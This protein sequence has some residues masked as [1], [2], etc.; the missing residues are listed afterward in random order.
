MGV[1]SGFVTAGFVSTG[2][3]FTS[4][5]VVEKLLNPAALLVAL[6]SIEVLAA[7]GLF[8]ATAPDRV[9]LIPGVTPI[10]AGAFSLKLL[11]VEESSASVAGF[12]SSA[13]ISGRGVTLENGL[14]E[15]GAI[16]ASVLSDGFRFVSR[17]SSSDSSPFQVT[18]FDR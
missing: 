11:E 3:L 14:V 12:S 10:V 7:I 9:L 15:A 16:F 6:F 1:F 18:V 8:S 4:G 17:E 5:V 2:G 13:T